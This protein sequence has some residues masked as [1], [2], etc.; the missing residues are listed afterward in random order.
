[1]KLFLQS[2]TVLFATLLAAALVATGE[3]GAAEVQMASAPSGDVV[4]ALLGFEPR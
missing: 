4:V 1:M 2:A 3:P